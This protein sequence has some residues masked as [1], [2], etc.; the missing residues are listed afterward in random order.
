[1]QA[2][3]PAWRRAL[4]LG[5]VLVRTGTPLA[6]LWLKAKWLDYLDALLDSRAVRPAAK[7]VDVHRNTAF[8]WRHRFLERVIN[9]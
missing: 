2:A 9:R 5:A 8:R 6:R 7:R 3:R 4:F 1:M